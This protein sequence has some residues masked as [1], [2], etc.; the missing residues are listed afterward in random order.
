MLSTYAL[1]EII[2]IRIKN[3]T[4]KQIS[5]NIQLS[6]DV[7]FDAMYTDLQS[8]ADEASNIILDNLCAHHS[9]IH[10]VQVVNPRIED[11]PVVCTEPYDESTPS[12][13]IE[14]AI[15]FVKNNIDIR[16]VRMT[17]NKIYQEHSSLCACDPFGLAAKIRDLMDEYGSDNNLPDDWWR[18]NFEFEEEDILLEIVNDY[19]H[20][21]A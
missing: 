21:I 10:G 6:V 17:L 7:R 1:L 3:K 5:I 2:C 8:V 16:E 19:Y 9:I 13:D 20:E 12:T 14:K 15:A 11:L 18:I 4:M